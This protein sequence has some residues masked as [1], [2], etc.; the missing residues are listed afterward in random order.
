MTKRII[1]ENDTLKA[2]GYDEKEAIVDVAFTLV[3]LA[4]DCRLNQHMIIEILNK[5]WTV[6]K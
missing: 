5:I 6:K 4:K 1:I 3:S 2:E